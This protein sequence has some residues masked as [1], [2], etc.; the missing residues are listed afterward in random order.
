MNLKMDSSHILLFIAKVILKI[1]S[2]KN[3]NIFQPLKKFSMEK[4]LISNTFF[5]STIKSCKATQATANV[6]NFE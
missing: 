6:S 4:K 5:N 3:L 2:K 1:S